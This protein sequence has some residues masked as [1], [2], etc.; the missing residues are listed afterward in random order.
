MR[1]GLG[2][3]IVIAWASLAGSLH[4][5]NVN[6]THTQRQGK[7]EAVV[8]GEKIDAEQV[9]TTLSGA[10]TVIFRVE[11]GAGLKVEPVVA[12]N[13]SADWKELRR[14]KETYT[15]RGADGK[16][17]EQKFH[18]EP[19]KPGELNLALVPLRYREGSEDAWKTINWQPVPVKVTTQIANPDPSQLRPITPPEAVSEPENDYHWLAWG[20]VAMLAVAVVFTAWEIKRRLSVAKP[21][22]APEKRALA[23]L[24]GIQQMG[25]PA[26]GDGIRHHALV[27]EVARRY[28][29]R[30]FQLKAPGRTTTE[31]LEAMRQG[32]Q[33]KPE[34]FAMLQEALDRCD[35]A[36]FAR[37]SPTAEECDELG[38]NVRA[39]VKQTSDAETS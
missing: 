18:L 35:L 2:Q 9:E 17:W 6:G 28:F 29:E 20:G 10:V 36:K 25:L 37:V 21:A 34:Q 24:E 14:E 19:N 13:A 23:E 39:L 5:D 4:A 26:D 15:P 22:M 11:G 33:L 7:A 12:V 27:S 3:I 31:F 38:R 32:G 16:V 30:R 1:C 8:V